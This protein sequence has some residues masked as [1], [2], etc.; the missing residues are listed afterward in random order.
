MIIFIFFLIKVNNFTSKLL[1]LY[2][3]IILKSNF[4]KKIVDSFGNL[5]TLEI[6]FEIV[7][8]LFNNSTLLYILYY[9][10]KFIIHYFN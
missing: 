5:Y 3:Y 4:L 2:I 9:K 10:Y 1:L 6:V 7:I 8:F